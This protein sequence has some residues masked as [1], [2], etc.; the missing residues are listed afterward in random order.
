MVIFFRTLV[1][2]LLRSGK[3]ELSQ[4]SKVK[5]QKRG[6]PARRDFASLNRA[7]GERVE[8]RADKGLSRYWQDFGGW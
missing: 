6:A 2:D 4:K 8:V 5:R 7:G 1:W 3:P